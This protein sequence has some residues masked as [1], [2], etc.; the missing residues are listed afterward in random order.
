MIK[1]S[2]TVQL[3]ISFSLRHNSVQCVS[4]LARVIF[5]KAKI[6][7]G[8]FKLKRN[9]ACG[10]GEDIKKAK[11]IIL[12]GNHCVVEQGG[13]HSF[14]TLKYMRYLHIERIFMD[15]SWIFLKTKGFLPNVYEIFV[16]MNCPSASNRFVFAKF[17]PGNATSPHG[18]LLLERDRGT[19]R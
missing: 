14:K 18:R 11:F 9:T 8:P 1:E 10:R 4:T 3:K 5:N 16:L 19:A 2:W 12:F 6:C 17:I 15:C 13:P 7:R